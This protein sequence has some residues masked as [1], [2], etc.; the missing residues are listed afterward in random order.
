MLN[1][2]ENGDGKSRGSREIMG[3]S[4][5]QCLEGDPMV[6][7]S[8]WRS[9]ASMGPCWR[10]RP[11]LPLAEMRVSPFRRTQPVNPPR[12]RLKLSTTDLHLSARPHCCLMA[13]HGPPRRILRSHPSSKFCLHTVVAQL[14]TPF[15]PPKVKHH[16]TCDLPTRPRRTARTKVQK[17][18]ENRRA[19]R[20]RFSKYLWVSRNPWRQISPTDDLWTDLRRG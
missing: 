14:A 10:R 16:V 12:V 17:Q 1:V 19:T 20:R 11:A 7:W 15:Y 3:L 9:V 6:G 4:C 2:A 18:N 5:F 13:T 8:M